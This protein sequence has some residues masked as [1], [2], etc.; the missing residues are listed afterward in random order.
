[1][2]P[3]TQSRLPADAALGPV[4]LRVADGTRAAAW[5]HRVLGLAPLADA[6]ART[7]HGTAGGRAL[8]ELREVAGLRR[9]PPHG[10][11]GPYH[12]AILLPTRADLG[13]FVAHLEAIG[14][15]YG[16]SDHL[17]SE[18]IYLTDPDGLTVEVY[19]DRPRAA[20]IRRNGDIVGTLDPLDRDSVLRAA[21][22]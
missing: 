15:P 9:A 2:E 21:G 7:R 14:E 4:R 17:F 11:L 10:L 1:M 16:S 3:R 5:L 20:W 18:A 13:R 12:Y 22:G 8:V 19:A 6:D